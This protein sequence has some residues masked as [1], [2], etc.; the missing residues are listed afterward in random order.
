MTKDPKK[1]LYLSH[2]PGL[3]SERLE[4]IVHFVHGADLEER[5]GETALLPA[6]RLSIKG[7]TAR[8]IT[9]R[10][11]LDLPLKSHLGVEVHLFLKR[12]SVNMAKP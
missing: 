5:G 7:H 9:G 6:A 1:C 3:Q 2:A 4:I 12:K 10:N 11:T 8:L